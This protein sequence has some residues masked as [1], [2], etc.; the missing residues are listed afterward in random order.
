MKNITFMKPIVLIKSLDDMETK[1]REQAIRFLRGR[2]VLFMTKDGMKTA[3]F[4]ETDGKL[5]EFC[6]Y[7]SE[8]VCLYRQMLGLPDVSIRTIDVNKILTCI[9]CYYC[10]YDILYFLQR[11]ECRAARFARISA[12][13]PPHVIMINEYRMLHEYVEYL[14]DNNWCGKPKLDIYNAENE[15][16]CTEHHEDVRRS[17]VDIGF[18]LVTNTSANERKREE[19]N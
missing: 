3:A 17:L 13:N 12:I 9:P 2:D 6:F 14:Q 1:Q 15:D 16:G 7:G 8:A 19:E 18:D 5:P 4:S 11:V 10:L